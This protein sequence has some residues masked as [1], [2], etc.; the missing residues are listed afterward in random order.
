MLHSSYWYNIALAPE[1]HHTGDPSP[2][3]LATSDFEHV[4]AL[5]DPMMLSRGNK[6]LLSR[7]FL[8]SFNPQSKPKPVDQQSSRA[9]WGFLNSGFGGQ[10]VQG[11]GDGAYGSRLVGSG[12]PHLTQ[13]LPLDALWSSWFLGP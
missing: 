1:H 11:Q 12:T 10:M 7:Y 5:P 4:A 13:A 3:W 8:V 6:K 2:S 9:M